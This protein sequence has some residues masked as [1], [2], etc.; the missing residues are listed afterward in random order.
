MTYYDDI[1]EGYNQLHGDEQCEKARLILEN[2]A[3]SKNDK[4]L[5]VGCGTGIATN[6][7]NCKKIGIDPSEKLLAKCSFPVKTGI[8]EKLPFKDS[9]FNIVISLT[10]IHH[11][12]IKKALDEMFRVSK[13]DI[14]VS[15]I[16]K[17]SKV[18]D[19]KKYPIKPYKIIE[20]SHDLI[21]FFK[22]FI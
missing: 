3:I 21:F 15:I 19:I 20:E 17:S 13:R 6:L 4:L 9:E 1:A 10:V 14:I 8:A 16:K 12:R 7:F 22:K 11:C 5:D 2:I 18:E